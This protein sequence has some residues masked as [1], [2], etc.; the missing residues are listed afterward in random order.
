[1]NATCLTN[2]QLSSPPQMQLNMNVNDCCSRA[3]QVP[4][5][6]LHSQQR[7]I[8]YQISARLL[9]GLSYSTHASNLE[10]TFFNHPPPHAHS[11]AALF[12]CPCRLAKA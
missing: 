5:N 11:H 7:C 2:K 12:T 4:V 1:M 3:V 8:E 6:R 9:H 10:H